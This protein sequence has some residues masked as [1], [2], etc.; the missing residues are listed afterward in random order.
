MALLSFNTELN[1]KRVVP[2]RTDQSKSRQLLNRWDR[3]LYCNSV[4]RGDEI[5]NNLSV[6]RITSTDDDTAY[7][8]VVSPPP[9]GRLQPTLTPIKFRIDNIINTWIIDRSS[10]GMLNG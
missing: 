2:N 10:V 6:V 1:N 7:M 5:V 9:S 4:Y 3:L 8:N